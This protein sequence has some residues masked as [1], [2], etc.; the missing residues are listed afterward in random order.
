[1]HFFFLDDALELENLKIIAA[2]N[3]SHNAPGKA[4]KSGLLAVK[5]IQG[6]GG[7]QVRHV[8]VCV[9][10]CVCVRARARAIVI[11]IYIFFSKF[12]LFYSEN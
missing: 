9:C 10:V 7:V 12:I 2:A 4:G 1:M 6:K 3:R 11:I 5:E 8:C